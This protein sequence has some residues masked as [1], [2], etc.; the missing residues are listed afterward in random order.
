MAKKSKPKFEVKVGQE[1]LVRL[2][3]GNA[4]KGKVV[5]REGELMLAV[6]K[7]EGNIFLSG[8]TYYY[9]TAI[10]DIH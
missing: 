2:T 9:I 7:E 6:K 4:V 10:T 8:D 5:K 3:T 1:L